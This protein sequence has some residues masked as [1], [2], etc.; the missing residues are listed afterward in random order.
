MFKKKRQK[1]KREKS[2]QFKENPMHAINTFQKENEALSADDA[3]PSNSPSMAYSTKQK[4][5]TSDK[6]TANQTTTIQKANIQ[7][8]RRLDSGGGMEIRRNQMGQWDD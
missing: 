3:L 7:A 4:A 1:K 8:R 6:M 2:A 5:Q